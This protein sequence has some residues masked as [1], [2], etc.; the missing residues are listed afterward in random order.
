MIRLFAPPTRDAFLRPD[1]ATV[2]NFVVHVGICVALLVPLSKVAKEQILDR[3]V[4]F[5]VPPQQDTGTRER[6]VGDATA[7]IVA[8]EGGLPRGHTDATGED[9]P[10]PVK[11]TA[12]TIDPAD[13]VAPATVLPGDNALSV[14]EV[15]STVVRDPMSAAPEY[16]KSLLDRGIEGSAAV[17]FV[18][19]TDGVVDT[20]SYRVL[21]T[22][23]PDFA[24]AVRMALN[25]MR[26]RPAIRAGSKVRQLVEQTFSFRIAPRD[27]LLKP[28]RPN[29]HA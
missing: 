22:T 2:A 26:F 4:V 23:H 17:R 24:V 19:D 20:I 11:G 27:S 3:L 9:H 15:D 5:L 12:P 25:G 21:R 6:D 28:P 14:L 13:V 18:V 16:P 8:R 29:P 10:L 7:T 1:P